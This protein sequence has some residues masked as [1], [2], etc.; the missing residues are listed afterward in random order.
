MAW[1]AALAAASILRLEVGPLRFYR[2]Y[3]SFVLPEKITLSLAME[4]DPDGSR[5]LFMKRPI[6]PESLLKW[7]IG[8]RG[9]SLAEADARIR[10]GMAQYPGRRLFVVHRTIIRGAKGVTV[11]D[12]DVPSPHP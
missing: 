10:A 8:S 12:E 11:R 5:H 3:P 7:Q 2:L 1:M 6:D 4:A 9:P